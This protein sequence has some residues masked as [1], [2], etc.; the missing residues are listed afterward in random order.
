M[1]AGWW[2]ADPVAALAMLTMIQLETW[3]YLAGRSL[4]VP[5]P[6]ALSCLQQECELLLNQRDIGFAVVPGIDPTITADEERDR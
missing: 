6:R 5:F 4:S 3:P 1:I 2:W